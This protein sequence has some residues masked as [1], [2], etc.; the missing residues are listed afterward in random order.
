MHKPIV[1][2]FFALPVL[3]AACVRAS[4]SPVQDTGA[5]DHSTPSPDLDTADVGVCPEPSPTCASPTTNV[6]LCDP[7]CQTGPCNWCSAEKC[8]VSGDGIPRCVKMVSN[9]GVLGD[10]CLVSNSGLGSG[11]PGLNGGQYDSC[12]RGLIC[13]GDYPSNPPNTHCFQL[14]Q[15]GADCKGV[16]CHKRPVAP[17]GA[18]GASP[19]TASVCDPPY[20]TCSGS[21]PTNGFY[22]ECCN[23]TDGTGCGPSETCYLV[24]LPD[25][26]TKA[27]LTVCESWSGGGKLNS[28]CGSST[29]CLVGLYC[30]STGYCLKACDLSATSSSACSHCNPV[31]NQFGYCN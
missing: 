15:S 6:S 1:A 14:C 10:S 24:P 25:L 16:S 4:F 23:P 19:F 28:V 30:S 31:G 5:D 9:P 12:A 11:G 18:V 29:D 3:M 20:L 13:M 21:T 7:S 22:G 26:V 17:P 27:N 2:Y 8:T